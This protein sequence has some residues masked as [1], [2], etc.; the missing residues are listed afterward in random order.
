MKDDNDILAF[1]A[2][3]GRIMGVDPF[4]FN[5]LKDGSVENHR[6][7]SRK[8]NCGNKNFQDDE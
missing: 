1:A 8:K 3:N 7:N 6:K 2:F 5:S 4:C